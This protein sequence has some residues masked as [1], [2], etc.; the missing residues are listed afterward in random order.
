MATWPSPGGP[1]EETT[2]RGKE[3]KTHRGG[4]QGKGHYKGSRGAVDIAADIAEE[5]VVAPADEAAPSVVEV[6]QLLSIPG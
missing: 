3:G 4:A 5:V 1:S 2:A 6:G